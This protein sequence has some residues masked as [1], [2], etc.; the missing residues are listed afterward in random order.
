MAYT[1]LS[2][3]IRPGFEGPPPRGGRYHGFDGHVRGS[4]NGSRDAFF[5][6]GNRM[7]SRGGFYDGFTHDRREG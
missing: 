5:N 3:C 7:G 2:V 6:V 1:Y 4:Y